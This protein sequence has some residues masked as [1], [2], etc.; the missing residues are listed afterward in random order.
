M[1]IVEPSNTPAKWVHVF[2]ATFPLVNT[3]FELPELLV[4]L[5]P[6]LSSS[7]AKSIW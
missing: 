6:A 3:R 4:T 2:C 5:K 1:R 7:P